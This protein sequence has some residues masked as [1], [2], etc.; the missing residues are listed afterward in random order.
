MSTTVFALVC[1]C[2][3]ALY[4]MTPEERRR[5]AKSLMEWLHT[6]RVV[7]FHPPAPGD[8]FD[9]FLR[10]RN[11]WPVVTPLL[12]ATNAAVFLAMANA[13]GAMAEPGTLIAW[14][15]NY[16]PLTTNGEWSRWTSS[17]FVHA[18]VLHL[19]ATI[20]G[21]ATV[22]IVLERAI[23][24]L[25]FAVAF[26]AAGVVASIVSIETAPTTAVTLGASGALFGVYGLMVATTVCGYLRSPRMPLSFDA[27]MRVTAGAAL[28]VTHAWLTAYLPFAAELAGMTTGMLAGLVIARGVSREKPALPRA[29]VVALAT[30]VIAVASLAA[31]ESVI[32]ARP[33]LARVAVV[34]DQT[35]GEYT[36]AV[37]EFTGGR[38]P[39]K[40]LAHLIEHT[41]VPTLEA[42]RARIGALRGVPA[43]QAPLIAAAGQYFTLRAESWR[44][45]AEG[46][47][48][49]NSR[50]LRE[51]E[52]SERAAL[53]ALQRTR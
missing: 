47:R 33:E 41:L 6:V 14:G 29:A 44:R 46:L 53:E 31:V 35:A 16:P 9:A 7:A 43:D 28:C 11:R 19:V 13:P 40:A 1:L 36:R 15:A 52:R 10:A 38:M 23:G 5:L 39:A 22:G 48:S 17:L 45:R 37:K 27:L 30:L 21:L 8:P 32:D 24:S 49:A 2:G 18:G 12:I 42:E 20:A 51:A 4:F 26:L 3:A 34:E 50:L 25:A